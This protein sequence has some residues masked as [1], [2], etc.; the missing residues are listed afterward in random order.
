LALKA[1]ENSAANPLTPAEEEALRAH[2]GVKPGEPLP[3][4]RHP[5]HPGV[6]W[7]KVVTKSEDDDEDLDPMQSFFQKIY[8]NAT[9]DSQRAMLKSYQES[10]GT[11]LNTVWDDVK[12]APVETHPP[13]GMV[14]KKW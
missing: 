5:F 11:S 9:P 14:A 6:D 1:E 2:Y 8:K 3:R 4:P 13:N 12:D 7:D 10:N